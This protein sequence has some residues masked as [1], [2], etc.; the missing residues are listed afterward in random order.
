MSPG[1]IEE[2]AMLLVD[3]NPIYMLFGIAERV[4]LFES[5]KL[6][7]ETVGLAPEFVNLS[8]MVKV[9]IVA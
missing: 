9:R 2:Y 1:N 6:A 4:G 7:L 5:L 3:I 8:V